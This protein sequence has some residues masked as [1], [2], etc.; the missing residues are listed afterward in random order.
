MNKRYASPRRAYQV[1]TMH[2]GKRGAMVGPIYRDKAQA[3]RE[4][5]MQAH[6]HPQKKFHAIQIKA[7]WYDALPGGRGP[8]EQFIGSHSAKMN[9]YFGVRRH[10]RPVTK[11]SR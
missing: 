9:R 3:M 4:A 10:Y 11:R 6:R 8:T 2:K 5:A 1:M 7:N